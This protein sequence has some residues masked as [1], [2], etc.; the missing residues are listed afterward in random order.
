[1]GDT[2]PS[3]SSESQKDNSKGATEQEEKSSEPEKAVRPDPVPDKCVTMKEA[4]E[5]AK[6]VLATI[7]EKVT[8]LKVEKTEPAL[9]SNDDSQNPKASETEKD[10]KPDTAPVKSVESHKDASNEDIKKEGKEEADQTP[11]KAADQDAAKADDSPKQCVES[12]EVKSSKPEKDVKQD[13]APEI[14]VECQKEKSKG[15]DEKDKQ[16][17]AA[18]QEKV[19]EKKDEKTDT[20][21]KKSDD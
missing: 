19:A 21:S 1:M 8:D 10:A 16:E 13:T 15:N 3:E 5:V 11:E 7:S 12:P 20:N 9:K 4:E 14:S 6:Q 18:V 17:P 2:A